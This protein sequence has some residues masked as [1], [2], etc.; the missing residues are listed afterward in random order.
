MCIFADWLNWAS[1]NTMVSQERDIYIYIYI[2]IYLSTSLD[3][4]PVTG[5]YHRNLFL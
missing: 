5:E 1:L 2:Y 3:T 4:I